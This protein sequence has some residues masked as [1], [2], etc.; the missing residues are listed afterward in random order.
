MAMNKAEFEFLLKDSMTSSLRSIMND[1][2]LLDK[3]LK[4]ASSSSGGL[5]MLKSMVGGNLIAGGIQAIGTG[6]KDLAKFAMKAGTDMEKARISYQVLTG[7]VEKGNKLFAQT[8]EFANVTPFNTTEVQKA[9]KTLMAF[10]VQAEDILPTM[11]AIG[12]VSALSSRSFDDMAMIYGKVVA[13]GKL[14]GQELNMLVDAGFNP[15]QQISERTG[16]SMSVLRKRMEMGQI[17]VAEVQQAFMDA[18]GEG[19]R[20]NNGMDKISQTI[21]GKWSTL[22]GKVTFAIGGLV[23]SSSGFFTTIIDGLISVTN[24]MTKN[25]DT[26]IIVGSVITG[27][28]AGWV[29]YTAVTSGAAIA[30]GIMTAAQWALNVAMS[31]NPI[32]IIV[33]LVGGLIAA[34]VALYKTNDKVKGF[35]DG[36]WGG[37]K[38]FGDNVAGFVKK[39]FHPFIEAWRHFK[40]G[41]YSASAKALA[42]GA[43]NVT[44]LGL[45]SNAMKLGDG[46]AD[47]YN[48]ERSESI[49]SS[50]AKKAEEDKKKKETEGG[51]ERTMAQVLA[52]QKMKDAANGFNGTTKA[53][54]KDKSKTSVSGASSGRPTHINVEIDSL[55]KEF[56]IHSQN[57]EQIQRQ[58]KDAVSRALT[59]AVNDV[60]LVA[61]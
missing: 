55:V 36:I 48:D 23:E 9:G 54:A 41:N 34:F 30:T 57:L 39:T 61:G 17:G 24:W 13:N 47:A 51:T 49:K 21:G 15:L 53:K 12:D 50:L 46:V 6:L 44:P 42:M 38:K 26:L 59:S 58:V 10:G 11:N 8:S 18:T 22:M 33:V 3:K 2:G 60:N 1:A 32:G 37:I 19:G 4:D 29:L 56:N 52:A 7:D 31:A 25:V 35:F 27:L 28:I 45:V 20:Y 5:G 14:M 16:E 40:E 43:F